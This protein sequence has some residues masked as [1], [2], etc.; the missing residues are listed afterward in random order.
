VYGDVFDDD[1]QAVMTTLDH[2]Q[3]RENVGKMWARVGPTPDRD[4]V[5]R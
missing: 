1:L 2:A 5:N 3:S 4:N